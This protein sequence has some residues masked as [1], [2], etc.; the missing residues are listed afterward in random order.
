MDCLNTASAVFCAD[1]PTSARS[2]LLDWAKM[3]HVVP[4][5]GLNK[6]GAHSQDIRG[7][8]N[9]DLCQYASSCA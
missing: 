5:V 2:L 1:T 3:N 4:G 8:D 7:G 9:P 6:F